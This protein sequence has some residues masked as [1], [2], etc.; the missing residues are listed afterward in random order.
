MLEISYIQLEVFV[1]WETE[2]VELKRSCPCVV[3][4]VSET[5]FK[6]ITLDDFKQTEEFK[7]WGD[8]GLDKARVCQEMRPCTQEEVHVYLAAENERLEEQAK[9]ARRKA[10]EHKKNSNRYLLKCQL[11]LL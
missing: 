6:L 9:E 2:H 8:G 1:W 11:E 7:M 4:Q 5:G 10:D 3:S